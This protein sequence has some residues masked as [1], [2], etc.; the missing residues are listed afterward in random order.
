MRIAL[1]TGG[2]RGVY[3]LAGSQGVC[4]SADLFDKLLFYELTPS[5]VVPGRAVASNRQ[6]K[7]RIK[8]ENQSNTTHLYRLLAG[9]L[10]LPK[11]KREFKKTA[12]EEL[13]AFEAYSMTAIKIDVGLVDA[14]KAIIRPTEVLLENFQGLKK[15]VNFID[16]MARIMEVWRVASEQDSEVA[17]LLREHK[18]TLYAKD[19][20]H[21]D[22]EKA[23]KDI[24]NYLKT[25]YDPLQTIESYLGILHFS[26]VEE[27]SSIDSTEEFGIHDTNSPTI[28]RIENIR[29]WRK[30][31]VRGAAATQFREEIRDLYNDTCLFTGQRLPKLASISSAGVDAAHILPWASYGV[32]TAENGIC[33]SKQSHWAFDSGVLKFSFDTSINQYVITIPEIVSIEARQQNF[34][35]RDYQAIVGPVP[36]ER[37]PANK[38]FW[39]NPRYLNTFNEIMFAS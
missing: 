1:R 15:S 29:R 30:I 13:I 28:A 7:P 8:L 22:V 18:K 10:L 21:K 34:S 6:G 17:H 27:F 4:R 32:N 3:E 36:R 37:L 11:P 16:R 39:P 20:N 33:L 31:A 19:F 2:G 35:L 12:G 25:I 5:L 26:E 23:S 24:F 38:D 9:L 14:Q